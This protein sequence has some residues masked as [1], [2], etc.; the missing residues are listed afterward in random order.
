M[1]I[2]KVSTRSAKPVFTD[3]TNLLPLDTG[4]QMHRAAQQVQEY[5][6]LVL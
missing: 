3:V 2:A 4:R 5:S 1:V 6:S